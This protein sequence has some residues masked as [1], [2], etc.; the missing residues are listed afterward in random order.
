[1]VT[2]QSTR[3]TLPGTTD[4]PLYPTDLHKLPYDLR[5]C[6]LRTVCSGQK[7]IHRVL[8]HMCI[9]IYIYI[10]PMHGITK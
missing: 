2:L 10:Y 3:L 8:I 9:Y 5:V 6:I 4:L 1:M 7:K